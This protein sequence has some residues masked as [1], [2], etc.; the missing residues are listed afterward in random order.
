MVIGRGGGRIQRLEITLTNQNSTQ[1]EINRRLN[2]EEYL[3]SFGAESLV[4]Q[5]ATH[6][7]KDY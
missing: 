2:S 1:E 7:Y 3:L 6:K 4:F 5:F